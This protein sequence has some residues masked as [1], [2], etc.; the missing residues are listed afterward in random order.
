[1]VLIS[2][3]YNVPWVPVSIDESIG[4]QHRLMY[5]YSIVDPFVILMPYHRDGHTRCAEPECLACLTE[6]QSVRALDTRR[7]QYSMSDKQEN[8]EIPSRNRQATHRL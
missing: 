1:M 4:R 2:R 8:S 6:D 3:L 7:K 5:Y